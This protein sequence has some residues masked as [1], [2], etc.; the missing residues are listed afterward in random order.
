MVLIPPLL[1]TEQ[2]AR[3]CLI[4]WKFRLLSGDLSVAYAVQTVEATA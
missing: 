2:G 3:G 1:R 4:A